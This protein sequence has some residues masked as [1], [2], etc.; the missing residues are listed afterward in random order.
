MIDWLYIKITDRIDKEFAKDA[1]AKYVVLKIIVIDEI[2]KIDE[3]D[4][5]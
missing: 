4:G 2:D 5:I 1:K 3:F